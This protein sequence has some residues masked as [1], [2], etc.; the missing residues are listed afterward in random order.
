MRKRIIDLYENNASHAQIASI[1]G[2]LKNTVISVIKIYLTEDR[3]DSKVRGGNR[4]TS[5]NIEQKNIFKTWV[6]A[7]FRF[8]L[9]KIKEK[10]YNEQG[11]VLEN[12]Q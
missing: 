1:F 9:N 7:D 10:C 3:F 2:I 8:T 11:V 12:P 4:K 6:N 5:I